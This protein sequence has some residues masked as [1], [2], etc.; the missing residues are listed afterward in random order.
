MSEAGNKIW[1]NPKR[2]FFDRAGYTRLIQIIRKIPGIKWLYTL[3]WHSFARQLQCVR[4]NQPVVEYINGV[5]LRVL[6]QVMPPKLFRTGAY[7]ASILTP[8]MIPSGSQI[9]DMGTGTGIVSIFTASRA[10]RVVAV[11]INPEAVRCTQINVTRHLLED[12]IDVRHGDL[13]E[14]VGEETFDRIIFNPP[15]LKGTPSIPFEQ[16]LYGGDTIERFCSEAKRYLKENGEILL[17]LSTL[18]EVEQ[19]LTIARKNGF[20]IDLLSE[21]HY[22][23]ESLMLYRFRP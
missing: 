12:K 16:A 4:Y 17:L 18:A 2:L 22:I 1:T 13:F 7:L 3:F 21:K 20:S 11:D 9:L 19:I 8:E 23:N 14:S 10:S 5:P 6:P 15:F